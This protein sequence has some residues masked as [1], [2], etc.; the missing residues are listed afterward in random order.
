M[1]K[2]FKRLSS[3]FSLPEAAIGPQEHCEHAVW[4]GTLSATLLLTRIAD[5]LLL[6]VFMLYVSFVLGRERK[7]GYLEVGN[8][9]CFPISGCVGVVDGSYHWKSERGLQS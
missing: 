1:G 6:F 5:G 9:D 7:L 3:V 4:E 8:S 2:L